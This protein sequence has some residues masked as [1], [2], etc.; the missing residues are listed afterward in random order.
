METF[1]AIINIIWS[2]FGII[3]LVRKL[4]SLEALFHMPTLE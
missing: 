2:W 1:E 4:F 3:F